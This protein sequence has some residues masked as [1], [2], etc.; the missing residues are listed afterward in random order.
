MKYEIHISFN[1][2]GFSAEDVQE[3]EKEIANIPS[4]QCVRSPHFSPISE[5]VFFIVI[6]SGLLGGIAGGFLQ[7][8]GTDIWNALKEKLRKFFSKRKGHIYLDLQFD[9][10]RISINMTSRQGN[11]LFDV[12]DSVDKITADIQ[13]AIEQD[14]IPSDAYYLKG[15]RFSKK[16]NIWLVTLAT[17]EKVTKDYKLAMKTGEWE[18]EFRERSTK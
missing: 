10:C 13:K 1:A 14:K 17:D 18:V 2:V 4:C 9:D 15:V 5:D 6:V 11:I 12:M 16:D 7:A 8:I 3:F